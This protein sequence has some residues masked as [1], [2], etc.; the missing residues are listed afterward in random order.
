MY[1]QD[2][3]TNPYRVFSFTKTG[4][5]QKVLELEKS[6]NINTV[7]F[8]KKLKRKGGNKR[9]TNDGVPEVVSMSFELFLK[10]LNK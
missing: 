1:T 2:G 7:L 9:R 6:G 8:W 5:S 10:L 3:I 4:P